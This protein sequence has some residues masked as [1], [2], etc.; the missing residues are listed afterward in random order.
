MKT[1]RVIRTCVTKA[2]WPLALI[3]AT[4]VASCVADPL[5]PSTPDVG[6][7]VTGVLVVNEGV[8]RQDNA[9]LT[10]YDPATGIATQDYFALRNPGLRL[11]DVANSIAVREGR[12]YVAVSTSRTVEVFDC[13]SGVS[14]GRVR[15][16]AGNEPR[17]IAFAGT[18]AFVSCFGDSVA[19]FDVRTLNLVRT[20][21]AGPAPE[22]IAV[23]GGRLFVAISGYGFYRQHEPMA[24]T[25]QVFDVVGGGRIGAIEIGPN[26]RPM[27]ADTARG[28]L[29]VLYGLPDS[30][31][32]IAEID[33][34][35]M[36]VVRR[37]PLEN[38]RE[39]ALDLRGRI[40][41]ATTGQGVM[42]IDLNDTL[43]AAT[44]LV[45]GSQWPG[46]IFYS[47]AAAPSGALY[48]ATLTSYTLPGEVLVF[49]AGTL[50]RRFP[51]GVNPGDIGFY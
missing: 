2:V 50:T 9:T 20:F 29:Y 37:W 10:L 43:T 1:E 40:A 16:P 30:L 48:L 42:R 31:G 39:M 49:E 45:A 6:G 5:P 27:I 21:A 36:M 46:R 12:A 14:L 28:L 15:L 34:R 33:A 18:S 19:Q 44:V 4:L 26:P 38:T 22:G 3:V 8:W 32:G 17:Q 11:G 13:D 41:Y 7:A 25:V 51:C 23:F 35:A 47:L 24:G